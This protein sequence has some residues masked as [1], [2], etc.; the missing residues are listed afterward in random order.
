MFF[1]DVLLLLLAAVL[2]LKKKEEKK[3]S[4]LFIVELI[5]LM[6]YDS[7]G[8]CF[9]FTQLIAMEKALNTLSLATIQIFA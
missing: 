1:W 9:L 5:I 2:T 4:K 7:S 8:V 6:W 3:K